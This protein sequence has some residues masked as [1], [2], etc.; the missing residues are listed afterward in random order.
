MSIIINNLANCGLFIEYE[1]T[2]ILV[3]ALNRP[4]SCFS[5]V[6][7]QAQEDIIAGR[8]IY[9]DLT[10]MLFTHCHPDHCDLAQAER[11]WHAHP[12]V[13][14]FLP[15]RDYGPGGEMT[16][17]DA[18]LRFR[19]MRHSGEEY[20]DVR[21]YV[22]HI[23]LDHKSIYIASDADWSTDEQLVFAEDLPID[24]AFFNPFYISTSRG[25]SLISHLNPWHTYIYHLPQ[26]QDDDCNMRAVA[27]TSMRKHAN[28][29]SD[30]TLL[31]NTPTAFWL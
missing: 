20:Q 10:A 18:T 1:E 4:Y 9:Q 7:A 31:L 15:D 25:R 2:R 16:L 17:G 19:K 13:P 22:F 30:C 3:D 27:R 11:F 21:L 12:D 29:L 23:T 26:E 24:A 6:D 14:L 5:A 28:E 8:G